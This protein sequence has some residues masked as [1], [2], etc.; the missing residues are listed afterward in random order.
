MHVDILDCL[1]MRNNSVSKC[2]FQI[3]LVLL[4]FY[5]FC[6]KNIGLSCWYAYFLLKTKVF[7]KFKRI[8]FGKNIR[9][10]AFNCHIFFLNKMHSSECRQAFCRFGSVGL[11]LKTTMRIGGNIVEFQ[12]FLFQNNSA[13]KVW[14]CELHEWLDTMLWE[15]SLLWLI[16][17]TIF[18]FVTKHPDFVDH[19]YKH[20]RKQGDV[21]HN[22]TD[23][24]VNDHHI[25]WYP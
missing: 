14:S 10:C 16:P 12:L 20:H 13:W 15:Q 3:H 18:T 22:I 11:I 23:S 4:Y 1:S 8:L 6:E 21:H 24:K 25:W 9:L 17:I 2:V 5:F 7:I 19:R